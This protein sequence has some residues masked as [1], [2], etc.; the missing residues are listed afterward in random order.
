MKPDVLIY[1]TGFKATELLSPIADKIQGKSQTLSNFWGD[2]PRGFHGITVPDFP[3]FFI[4]FGPN[5]GLGHNSIVF[6]IEC[7]V[8]YLIKVLS[9]VHAKNAASVEVK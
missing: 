9:S 3:N 2:W 8:N 4:L 1:G 5:I 6:M 7:Q